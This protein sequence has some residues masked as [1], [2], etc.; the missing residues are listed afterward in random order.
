M[1]SA[2]ITVRRTTRAAAGLLAAAVI[3]AVLPPAVQAPAAANGC[4]SPA[5]TYGG[6]DGS[7]GSPYQIAN[8]A[9]LLRLAAT[10]DDWA[11]GKHFLLTDD[12]DL[13]GCT[14][15]MI[16]DTWARRFYGSFDGNFQQITGLSMSNTVNTRNI[17]FFGAADSTATIKD[18]RLVEVSVTSTGNNV[19][20]LVAESS[21]TI[22]RGSVSGTVS[23]AGY[24][25]GLVGYLYDDGTITQSSSFATVVG[26]G[27]AV[28]GLVG[29]SDGSLVRSW[30]VRPVTG[31]GEVGGLVGVNTG[32]TISYSF[33]SGNVTV[34][35]VEAD[36]E[37]GAG[38]LVGKNTT[39]C[40]ANAPT[41]TIRASYATGT[42]TARAGFSG[43]GGLVGFND[44]QVII[45]SYAQGAVTGGTDIGGLVGM[46]HGSITDSASVATPAVGS[47]DYVDT[48]FDGDTQQ[49]V[50][51]PASGTATGLFTATKDRADY[52]TAGWKIVEEWDTFDAGVRDWGICS[53]QNGGYPYLLWVLPIAPT[54]CDDVGDGDDDG[55]GDGSGDENGDN[56]N[57][58]D[59]V[60]DGGDHGVGSGTF[61][62]WVPAPGG[63]PQLPAG[64]GE[65]QREDGTVVPLTVS[66]PGT[67]QVRYST[68]GLQVTLTGGGG[69]SASRGL[70][71]DANG[72]IACEVCT[73]VATGEVIEVWLFSEPRLVAAHL[74]DGLR[75]QTFTIPLGAP[76]DGGGPVSTGAHTLQLALP[77]A[78]GM[79]AVN[80]GVTVGGPVPASVPA[81][82][83]SVPMQMPLA[84]LLAAIMSVGGAVLVGRRLVTAG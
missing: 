28:G 25:G 81:G 14:W 80:V 78:S 8:T 82:E 59:S 9:Q 42:V 44:R 21:A 76:L 63:A 12:I 58:G 31:R 70:V 35:G 2:A 60:G 32:G 62:S 53:S 34:S 16:G 6:G 5:A 22:I 65:W 79:Q 67:R 74:T 64:D 23:G 75:C 15:T 20:G 49:E 48:V 26:T 61:T 38:G 7:G 41:A 45:D 13:T 66:S 39:C 47:S 18:I 29:A 71:A 27:T 33:A 40:G 24:V 73:D 56:G 37:T 52:V 50:S 36:G 77:T 57:D 51:T 3:V 1:R 4:P 84:L 68:D 10:P 72:E 19:G 69:S 30:A 43:S 55:N 11:A 54:G 17:G 83:G 46:N